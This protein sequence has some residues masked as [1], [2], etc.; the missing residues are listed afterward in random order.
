MIRRGSSIRNL[1]AF[2]LAVLF[3]PLVAFLSYTQVRNTVDRLQ[4]NQ[5]SLQATADAAAAGIRQFV[6]DTRSILERLAQDPD[7]RSMD[8]DRCPDTFQALGKIFIPTYTNLFTWTLDGEEICSALEPLPGPRSVGSPPRFQEIVAAQDFHI[9]RVHAGTATGIWTTGLSYPLRDGEGNKVGVITLSVDLIRFQ[10]ILQRLI[11]PGEGVVSVVEKDGGAFVA[12][13]RSP[14][15]FMGTSSDRFDARSPN[16]PDFSNRGF[17]EARTVEGE[18]YSWGFVLIPDTPWMV[19]AGRPKAALRE[20]FYR[21]L[22]FSTAGT[23]LFL[24]AAALL[25]V[26]AYRRITDPLERLVEETSEAKPGDPAPLSESGPEEIAL[27]AKRFNEAWT[28]WG[29]AEKERQ[30][31]M[32]RIRS[33]VENAVTGIYVS[34]QS[35]RFLEVNHAMVEMLGYQDR[36]EL[37]NTPV[38]ALYDSRAE[39]MEVLADQGRKEFFRGSEVTWRKKDGT[40]IHVRLF[41]RRFRDAQGEVSWEVIVEDVTQLR[42]LQA[43][44][45]QSQKMEALGRMAGGVAHDF[46]NILTVIQG[47]S[48]LILED[49]EI[50]A[51]LKSQIREINQAAG[52]GAELNRQLLAFG[53]RGGEKKESLDLNAVLQGFELVL[54]RAAGE[55]IQLR[56]EPGANVGWVQGNR[57]QLEQILMNL[58]VNA[59]DAMPAGG[60]LTLKTFEVHVGP[61]EARSNPPAVPGPHVVLSVQDSGTGISP[62][63]LPNIFDPFFSTK[64]ES[65]GTGLGLATVYGIVTEAGGHIRVESGEGRGTTFRLFFPRET[66]GRSDTVV[67]ARAGKSRGGSGRILLAEDEDAVRRLTHRIL[68]RAGYEVVVAR[69]GEEALAL[70][71]GKGARF[72]LLLSDVVMPGVRGPDLAELLAREGIVRRVVLFSGYPQGLKRAALQGLDTWELLPKP[73]S[74]GEL[75]AAVDRALRSEA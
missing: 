13:S 31:S 36:D 28:G 8:P 43:Q 26:W 42:S 59:R 55:E 25:G 20:P 29:E 34:T 58:V 66:P 30:R 21:W 35:G 52:R 5:E 23:L 73:F 7:L 72:D 18:E 56:L 10:E 47:Q 40:P 51:D 6:L 50:Q 53:R 15:E 70:A 19:Y 45:L 22:F 46:N 62:Q 39:R 24:L 11:P 44:Y 32:E 41:G 48:E 57:G 54:R 69:D 38:H 37:M 16:D 71:R 68:E 64:P 17:S 33:L 3:L 49:P 2:L 1:M 60:T 63:V 9:S 4:H 27:L 75:L 12:R 61:D 74:S 65:Q 14:E 67:R